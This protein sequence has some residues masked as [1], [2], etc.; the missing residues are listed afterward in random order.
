MQFC[1]SH[2]DVTSGQIKMCYGDSSSDI[3]S[4]ELPPSETHSN[5]S[6]YRNFS[7]NTTGASNTPVFNRSASIQGHLVY[8]LPPSDSDVETNEKVIFKSFV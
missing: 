2:S 5:K 7:Q 8:P 1:D 4:K 3:T 6:C